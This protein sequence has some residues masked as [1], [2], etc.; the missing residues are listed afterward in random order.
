M[1]SNFTNS[2]FKKISII[3]IIFFSNLYTNPQNLNVSSGSASL[4]A[5]SDTLNITTSD[6][7]ILN[8]DSFSINKNE[9]TNFIMPSSSS[10]SLN[11][12]LGQDLSSLMGKLNANG[13]IILVNPN[14]ILIGN[15]AYINTFSFI[16]STFDV[17]DQDFLNSEEYAFKGESKAKIENYGS[18]TATDGDVF[19]IG[20]Q[21]RNIGEINAKNSTAGIGAGKE[22]ILKPKSKEKIFIK[23]K[24]LNKDQDI[25]IENDGKINAAQIELK[26]D[27]NPYTLAI[28]NNKT[29]DALGTKVVDGKVFLVAE[30]GRNESY[31][32]IKAQ[33]FDGSGG[34]VRLLGK[35][36]G[37]LGLV[38][39]S[40]INEM[41]GGV[42]L[43]GGDYQGKN[44]DIINAAA[45]FM[46][47]N[48]L[49]NA[50]ANEIGNGGR[51]I[52]WSDEA[53]HFYGDINVEG[54]SIKGD[55]G[56]VEVSSK[57]YLN[58]QGDIFAKAYNGNSGTVL[59]DPTNITISSNDNQHIE[60][61]VSPN[62]VVYVII[63]DNFTGTS[64]IK[65][66]QIK[67]FLDEGNTVLI[68]THSGGKSDGN[69]FVDQNL[70][71]THGELFLIADND[72]NINARIEL[73]DNAL[74]LN[75][76]A[77][78]AVILGP[79]NVESSIINT[80][81]T[82]VFIN[83]SSKELRLVGGF[84]A[85]PAAS[86]I[87]PNGG[88]Y[89]LSNSNTNINIT[90]SSEHSAYIKFTNPTS[91]IAKNI[92]IT[93]NGFPAYIESAGDLTIHSHS[94]SITNN[95]SL[96]HDAYIISTGGSIN[97]TA[98]NNL[99]L[100]VQSTSTN[101]AYI[102][103]QAA[104]KDITI[105]SDTIEIFAENAS[106]KAFIATNNGSIDITSGNLSNPS[107]YINIDSNTLGEA[108]VAINETTSNP[109]NTLNIKGGLLYLGPNA[110]IR[111][112]NSGDILIYS[113]GISLNATA[114]SSNTDIIAA[115]TSGSGNLTINTFNNDIT[116][117]ASTNDA[118][119]TIGN[120]T[121]LIDISAKDITLTAGSA[122]AKIENFSGITFNLSGDLNLNASTTNIAGIHVT[123][124]GPINISNVKNINLSGTSVL[125]D[126]STVLGSLTINSTGSINLNRYSSIDSTADINIS[127]HGD[128]NMT[129]GGANELS[130]IKNTSGNITINNQG[131]NIT[132]RG[133]SSAVNAKATIQPS[134]NVTITTANNF[135]LISSLSAASVE[136]TG[137]FVEIFAGNDITANSG[138]I[139][140]ASSF[141]TFVVD[142]DNPSFPNYGNGKFVFPQSGVTFST[143]ANQL[144]SLYS[145]LQQINQVPNGTIING[146]TFTKGALGQNSSTE[147][148]GDI[149]SSGIYYPSIGSSPFGPGF[150]FYYKLT[151]PEDISRFLAFENK[152]NEALSEMFYRLRRDTPIIINPFI[153]PLKKYIVQNEKYKISF[154]KGLSDEE[155]KINEMKMKEE[156]E[157]LME[158]ENEESKT[159]I[160]NSFKTLF[161]KIKNIFK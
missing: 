150:I 122:D 130:Q 11:R 157:R 76:I 10:I 142:N 26:A 34:E 151:S 5:S 137:G 140:S 95:S 132:L 23:S 107:F 80:S 152:V 49:I 83:I 52:L 65:T 74:S 7:T 99:S 128:L 115:A 27:G 2:I 148:W 46:G 16:G 100:L 72:I 90:S 36:V 53:T 139:F 160:K 62:K 144:V 3:S 31:G 91:L 146:N 70:V 71:F 38:D 4:Q 77:Q 125:A 124:S 9:T 98:N 54:G 145:S 129:A 67:T 116:F 43:F 63:P 29:L 40:S 20:Y 106:S 55:G 153:A 78:K 42:V 123:T 21:I 134:G 127:M 73:L 114:S 19:L 30:N 103:T 17:L 155:I 93:S 22:I 18:I 88:T 28:K 15:E 56:F 94:T 64:F 159:N 59:F 48:A 96:A 79:S 25:G 68:N 1:K 147:Q 149:P 12:V 154:K 117:D 109:N 126:I 85:G 121:G 6:K 101:K 158:K 136:T 131:G 119:F 112:V 143:G 161:E 32:D 75:L 60:D 58:V 86:F 87:E 102:Q 82:D 111:S 108:Y 113:K 110:H 39:V 156:K 61:N 35:E 120:G 69:I 14:G 138:S 141:I 13:K 118:L 84:G 81:A 51:V 47:K 105:E 41:N 44:E 92:N 135:N 57:N 33:N 133:G 24:S 89:N 104:N 66:S 37:L 97:I 50:K 8:W 45:I